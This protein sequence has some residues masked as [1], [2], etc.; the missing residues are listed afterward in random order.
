VRGDEVVSLGWCFW[1]RGCFGCLLCGVGLGNVN[2]WAVGGG[3]EEDGRG[4]ELDKIP[5]CEWCEVETRDKGYGEKKV[6]ERGLANVSR[7]D[8]GLTRCRLQRLDEDRLECEGRKKRKGK[9]KDIVVGGLDGEM[10]GADSQSSSDRSRRLT[11]INE[12]NIRKLIKESSTQQVC[13][14]LFS[15]DMIC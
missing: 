11:A 9:R 14:P 12:R 8:G 4:T 5:L 7:Y 6:L 15:A 10:P 1:H 2:T 3:E 13:N